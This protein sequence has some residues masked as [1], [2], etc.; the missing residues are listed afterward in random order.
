MKLQ[1]ILTIALL[2][3][4]LPV[5]GCGK[6]EKSA[7]T[8]GDQKAEN[9]TTENVD[10]VQ[11]CYMAG[12]QYAM[13][14]KF[15][16]AEEQFK[17]AIE[18]DPD[19]FQAY[20]KLGMMYYSMG[21]NDEA[22][23][24][25]DQA[26]LLNPAMADDQANPADVGI[27]AQ[28]CAMLFDIGHRN[29]A[30]E[31]LLKLREFYPDSQTIKTV[32]LF[33]KLAEEETP[34]DTMLFENFSAT[35]IEP[36]EKYLLLAKGYVFLGN[37]ESAMAYY[38]K[39]AQTCPEQ[40]DALTSAAYY[41]AM[42]RKPDKAIDICKKGLESAPAYYP[43]RY[44]LTSVY[45]ALA[46]PDD[47]IEAANDGVL[48][49]PHDARF[50]YLLAD[51]YMKAGRWGA[52]VGVYDAML[53]YVEKDAD[54][55]NAG[56]AEY[57][58]SLENMDLEETE[59]KSQFRKEIVYS[60]AA[61]CLNRNG[62]FEKAAEY[63][64]KAIATDQNF[65]AGYL[66]LSRAYMGL[67]EYDK[68]LEA[69]KQGLELDPSSAELYME[70]AAVYHQS[71]QLD[72]AIAPLEK[73]IELNPNSSMAYQGL[74]QTYA[75]MQQYEKALPYFEKAVKNN[76]DLMNVGNVVACY[77]KLGQ[78][79]AALAAFTTYTGQDAAAFVSICCKDGNRALG[80][81]RYDDAARSFETAI[82]ADKACAEAVYGLG[83]VY[84][85][86]EQFKRA[87]DLATALE[88]LDGGLYEQLIKKMNGGQR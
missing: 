59:I 38:D 43:L 11:K 37:V 76:P 41:F 71:E 14:G 46:M 81:Q 52:A 25:L 17:K 84:V 72:K 49:S 19:Y 4:L 22:A 77:V 28:N 45:V 66:N 35:D 80:E 1:M 7:Q 39:V 29:E 10:A 23:E 85:E 50:Y 8:S 54:Y 63:A 36:C 67:K 12:R 40:P 68:S 44:V 74:A 83:C 79:E 53:S 70:K 27:A 75:K 34:G 61:M 48:A 32:E 42:A 33:C 21:R 16:Q 13:Q 9:Q 18:L 15:D 55:F 24:F 51:R 5:A 20:D 2:S 26:V 56:N 82:F 6:K 64:Q 65:V 30:F 88:P 62:N 60:Q 47:A 3:F 87:A 78:K 86:Q 69:I 31:Y 57:E 73:A 58:E